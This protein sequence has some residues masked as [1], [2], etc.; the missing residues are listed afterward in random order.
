MNRT[1]LHTILEQAFQEDLGFGDLSSSSVFNDDDSST[2][3][4]TI[5]D[6][7]II[8]GLAVLEEAYRLLDS[9][10]A[11]SFFKQDGTFVEPGDIIAEVQGPTQHLLSGERVILNLLQHMSGIATATGKAVKALNDP[12]IRICDTRKTLPG[13]RMLQKHAVRCGG[14]YNHRYRL[15]DGIM[16]KDNHIAAA[17]S[18]TKAVERARQRS[19]LMIRIEVETETERQVREAVEAGADIIMLDNRSPQEVK[20]LAQIIPD[21]IVTEV[22]GG[23][24]EE[25]IGGYRHTNVDYISLGYLTHSVQA[26]DISFNLN[27]SIKQDK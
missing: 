12:D 14:G 5:K 2:G 13:L 6:P 27:H 23:I 10:I 20:K 26:L 24:T 18:I 3:V 19:G 4:F 8:A 17:G 22:S 21:H 16:I 1:R 9:S 15:D 11:V 25:N 7:G